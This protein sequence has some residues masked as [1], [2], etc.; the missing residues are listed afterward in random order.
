MSLF[1]RLRQQVNEHSADLSVTHGEAIA[2][3]RY[4]DEPNEHAP[5]GAVLFDYMARFPDNNYMAIQVIADSEPDRNAGWCQ[6]V[7]FDS[8]GCELGCTEPDSVFLGEYTVGDYTANV[9]VGR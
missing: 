7:L 5:R 1:E 6:G 9:R 4:L 2:A 8:D 3:Q